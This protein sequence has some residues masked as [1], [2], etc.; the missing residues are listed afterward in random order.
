MENIRMDDNNT[1]STYSDITFSDSFDR[2]KMMG[3]RGKPALRIETFTRWD[4]ILPY[5]LIPA[6]SNP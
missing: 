4:E 5:G 1:K 2:L 6:S 3:V